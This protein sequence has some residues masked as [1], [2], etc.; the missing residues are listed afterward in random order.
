MAKTIRSIKVEAVVKALVYATAFIG[1]LATVGHAGI[2]YSAGFLILCFGSMYLDHRHIFI[3]RWILNITV[4]IFLVIAFI[5]INPENIIIPAIDVLLILIGLKFLEDKKARDYMQ[6][7]ILS[8]FLLAGSTLLSLDM[9]FLVYFLLFVIILSAVIILISYVSEDSTLTLSVDILSRIIARS[10]II[11]V[12]AIP[13]AA[14][15]FIILPR[16]S[17]PMFD[18]FNRASLSTSGFSDNV[19]L[20]DVSQIQLE[21]AIVFRANVER[22]PEHLMYWRG[23]V[24][25]HF[26]GKAW[27][28]KK[29]NPINKNDLPALEGHRIHY[30]IYLEPSIHTTLFVLDKP[31]FIAGKSINKYDTL[32]YSTRDIKVKTIRY[33]AISVLSGILHETAVDKDAYLQLPGPLPKIEEVVRTITKGMHPADSIQAIASYFQ[34]NKF[35]YS[36]DNL[37]VTG[38]PL[39]DF[40]F[41][42]RYGNCEFFAS[43]MAVML[44]IAG[45]PARLV[46]GYLGGYYSDLGKYY[47]VPQK[48]AH[49]WVEAYVD[50]V[51]WVR[52]DPTP[53]APEAYTSPYARGI[54]F[55]VRMVFDSL[56]YYWNVFVINY[57]LQ[58]QFTLLTQLKRTFTSPSFRV[59]LEKKTIVIGFISLIMPVLLFLILRQFVFQRKS[60]EERLIRLFLNRMRQRGYEKKSSE[61]LEEF[62]GQVESNATR[63]EAGIFVREFQK[64]YYHDRNVTAHDAAMLRGMIRRIR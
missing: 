3:P 22:I 61:G 23:I 63:A 19:R 38:T 36:L 31:V 6:I 59:T 7:S 55:T 58:K 20:G 43:A 14:A 2:M 47:A 40:L 45:I 11:P 28:S 37:P 12:I 15:L 56:R 33:T 1:F 18:F 4:L 16:T 46:G 49:V 21:E 34:R 41:I 13:L 52:Y 9:I 25:D 27:Q 48:N 5:R 57:D 44:R 35:T 60:P 64:R 8:V 39:Q 30:T 42:H 54:F 51:G 50:G 32:T 29:M 26:D 53:A 17:Y 10:L 62:L 24:F